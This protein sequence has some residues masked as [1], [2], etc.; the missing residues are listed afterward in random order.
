VKLDDAKKIMASYLT[1]DTVTNDDL[2]DACETLNRGDRGYI[3]FLEEEF[4]LPDAT[5]DL[6]EV[7]ADR[8][9]EFG[10]MSEAERRAELPELAAHVEACAE[11]QSMY[12][13][14]YLSAFAA[15]VNWAGGQ[16]RRLAEPIRLLVGWAGELSPFGLGP[17]EMAPGRSVARGMA[18]GPAAPVRKVWELHLDEKTGLV[19]RVQIGS[20][21]RS[22][23]E[24]SFALSGPASNEEAAGMRV[25]SYRLEGDKQVGYTSGPL[26]EFQAKGLILGR[27]S[28]LLRLTSASGIGWE[29][30][31]VVNRVEED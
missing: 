27:G 9:A 22:D 23:V 19:L 28:W 20:L 26:S 30:P 31:L 5:P 7:F 17:L 3:E 10:E 29:I 12:R 4:G 6:C 13:E 2:V 1:G 8:V 18:L 15:G 24:V 16:L 25:A 14:I 11:C 21:K